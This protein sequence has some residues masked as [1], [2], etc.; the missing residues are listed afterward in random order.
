MTVPTA[1]NFKFK[2]AP[3]FNLVDDATIEFAIEEAVVACNNWSTG[4]VDAWIDDANQ[5]LGIY[6]YA[7]HILQVSIMRGLSATG[8]VVSSERTPDLSVT[9]AVPNQNTPI[10]F[11]M[12]I[13]GERFIGLVRK[14]FPLVLTVN[15][16]V[17]M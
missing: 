2:F 15:S 4:D 8:Q 14:N 11:T 13:Y 10:D 12:T 3:A 17:R 5:T 7:A 16:A 9:Y 1:A 6:Y